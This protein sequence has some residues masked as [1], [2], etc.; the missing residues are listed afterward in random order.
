[1]EEL[2]QSGKSNI[3]RWKEANRKIDNTTDKNINLDT[4]FQS[5][6]RIMNSALWCAERPVRS[7][8][9]VC[10]YN[11]KD[12]DLEQELVRKMNQ[13]FSDECGVEFAP[14]SKVKA[15]RYKKGVTAFGG[16]GVCIKLKSA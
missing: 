16:K 3:R 9:F 1:M 15:A 12:A 6:V 11:M 8:M 5:C 7:D 2:I 4:E 14:M 13:I 10:I